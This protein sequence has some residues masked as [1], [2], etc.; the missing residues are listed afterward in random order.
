MPKVRLDCT[1]GRARRGMTYCLY[2]QGFTARRPRTPREASCRQKQKDRRDA[3]LLAQSED[4]RAAGI[5]TRRPSSALER[6]RLSLDAEYSSKLWKMFKAAAGSVP[7]AP[8]QGTLPSSPGS[9][10]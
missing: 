6:R 4:W 2:S 9:P 5:R 8:N 7:R 1:A 3:K 10:R